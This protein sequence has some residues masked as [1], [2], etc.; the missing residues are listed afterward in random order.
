MKKI[1]LF[2]M[3]LS[4]C[5]HLYSLDEVRIAG[6]QSEIDER[7]FYPHMVFDIILLQSICLVI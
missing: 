5:I 3:L 1:V 7:H 6:G 2:T 4:L